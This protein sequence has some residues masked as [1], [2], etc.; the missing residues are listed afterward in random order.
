[1]RLQSPSKPIHAKIKEISAFSRN[2]MALT[3]SGELYSWGANSLG[4]IGNGKGGYQE[5]EAHSWLCEPI[6]VKVLEGVKYAKAGEMS[7]CMITE[8]GD[9]YVCGLLPLEES[10]RE[11][12]KPY[13][14]MGKVKH[15]TSLLLI[16]MAVTEDGDLY[17]WGGTIY[18]CLSQYSGE[19]GGLIYQRKIM[20]GVQSVAVGTNHA[21][22]LMENGDL[23][24]WGWNDMGQIGNGSTSNESE[25]LYPPV[26]IMSDIRDIGSDCNT[27][28]AITT[29]GDLYMW[30]D[31]FWGQVGSGKS[32]YLGE[33]GEESVFDV[34]ETRPV[35]VLSGVR[36]ASTGSTHTV[37]VTENG[38]LYMWGANIYGQFGNGK[39]ER[40]LYK[41]PVRIMSGVKSAAAGFDFTIVL[42]EDGKVYTCGGNDCGQLGNGKHGDGDCLS[43]LDWEIETRP[44]LIFDGGE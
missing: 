4:E 39:R 28:L 22:A 23:Y 25:A 6:P 33:N 11:K 42:M 15:A 35:K 40:Q 27:S 29:G 26:K 17:A 10:D 44:V 19:E 5:N 43:I 31:T 1:M 13:K 30:G 36:C 37:A 32:G 2:A 38:D 34:Y 16:L 3:E 9:L 18:G 7:S 8:N 12:K 14:I 41:T 20:S 21:L 24:A